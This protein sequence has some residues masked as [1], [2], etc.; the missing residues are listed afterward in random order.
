MINIAVD[1]HPSDKYIALPA[2]EQRVVSRTVRYSD[3]CVPVG[4]MWEEFPSTWV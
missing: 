4:S 1:Y 3:R 2:G